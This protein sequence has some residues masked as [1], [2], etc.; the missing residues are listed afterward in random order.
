MKLLL[1]AIALLLQCSIGFSARECQFRLGISDIDIVNKARDAVCSRLVEGILEESPDF[2]DKKIPAK[3]KLAGKSFLK[4]EE[5]TP[6]R[7][8]CRAIAA[9]WLAC[10]RARTRA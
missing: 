2:A 4:R 7:F 8:P 10:I 5:E 1:S 3:P 9:G 6:D